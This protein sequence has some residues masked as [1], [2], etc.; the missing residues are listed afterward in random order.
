M[1]LVIDTQLNDEE[2][3]QCSHCS[4][5]MIRKQDYLPDDYELIEVKY[6][7]LCGSCMSYELIDS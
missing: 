4:S 5:T 3:K 1:Q 6:F 7:W 2:T